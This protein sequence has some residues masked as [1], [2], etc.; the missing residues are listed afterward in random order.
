MPNLRTAGIQGPRPTTGSD[1]APVNQISQIGQALGGVAQAIGDTLTARAKTAAAQA[2]QDG[3]VALGAAAHSLLGEQASFLQESVENEM[4]RTTIKQITED[5]L[6]VGET[7]GQA[8]GQAQR[9]GKVD[10]YLRETGQMN[11]LNQL[12]LLTQQQQL[13][14]NNPELA[15]DILK[16]AN[17]V[18]ADSNAI[19]KRN[20][21]E[22]R[23]AALDARTKEVEVVDAIL[24]ANNENTWGLSLAEKQAKADTWNWANKAIELDKR[25][26]EALKQDDEYEALKGGFAGDERTFQAEQRARSR[27]SRQAVEKLV[28]K[29]VVRVGQQAIG[30]A[31]SGLPPEQRQ[32]QWRQLQAQAEADL[33]IAD[34]AMRGEALTRLRQAYQ[35]RN[36]YISGQDNN[37]ALKRERGNREL[38]AAL[39]VYDQTPEAAAFVTLG[40]ELL[41]YLELAMGDTKV[42]AAVTGVL[43]S[44]ISAMASSGV[45]VINQ[46]IETS[47]NPNP[48]GAAPI[49]DLGSGDPYLTPGMQPRQ[50]TPAWVVAKQQELGGVVRS[51]GLAGDKATP[52]MKDLAAQTVI[53]GFNSP[54]VANS[55]SHV[56]NYMLQLTSPDVAVAFQNN[57]KQPEAFAAANESIGKYFEGVMR[58]VEKS[59]GRTRDFLGTFEVV[60]GTVGFRSY[61]G[62]GLKPELVSKI[63]MEVN[64]AVRALAHLQ[65]RTD[66]TEVANEFFG[67]A[68]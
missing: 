49:P 1:A 37:E 29:L 25:D 30:L 63:N 36:S 32:E 6:S 60:N 12:R 45:R 54:V 59:T 21:D 67:A 10:S 3:A 33:D 57:P 14:G 26:L 39:Q 35:D 55:A 22:A 41:P 8:L 17:A 64:Q 13:V 52:F 48:R 34:P 66:Y 46:E 19:L 4:L 23:K 11:T 9:L 5:G 18:S 40:G 44:L 51:V 56:K 15:P 61:G 65:G 47:S 31:N 38:G 42:Q 27:S 7:G 53:S 62:S 50:A 28:P 24:K 68:Q 43:P 16:L 2:E 20:E 58:S